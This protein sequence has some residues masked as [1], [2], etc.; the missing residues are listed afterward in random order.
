MRAQNVIS[1]RTPLSS[2]REKCSF[3]SAL[4][5]EW[6]NEIR[7]GFS[8]LS[9]AAALWGREPS[10]GGC[11]CLPTSERGNPGTQVCSGQQMLP[12]EGPSWIPVLAPRSTS[13]TA[14]CT[15]YVPSL[16]LSVL[17]EMNALDQVPARLS[18]RMGLSNPGTP[19]N[20][21]EM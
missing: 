2:D 15:W 14:L 16:G 7:P 12:W 21:Q 13:W 9:L 18:S 4:G 3:F 11:S 17:S 10:G 1:R 5:S 19:G 20:K 6:H 8:M